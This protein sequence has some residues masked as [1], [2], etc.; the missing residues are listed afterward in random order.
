MT[1]GMYDLSVK[2]WNPAAGCKFDCSYCYPSFRAQAK[3]Q[4]HR[5][6][7]CYNYEPHEHPE[8]LDQRLPLTGYGQF[9]FAID[10]GDPAFVR[11][12]YFRKVLDRVRR[13]DGRTFLFQSKNPAYFE[14]FKF[15]RNVILGATIETNRDELVRE[16]VSPKVPLPTVRY[17]SMLGLDHPQKMVTIEPIMKFDLPIMVEWVREIAPRMVWM[18]YNSY[19]KQVTLP[20]PSLEEFRELHFELGKLGILTK[21]KTV[22]G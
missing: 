8:R 5:C 14:D 22:R 3:R 20:E 2:Q 10:M 6:V 11:P 19:P 15:P 17:N 13:D 1:G 21:L 18:G 7:G 12:E 9:I 16:Y 4:K